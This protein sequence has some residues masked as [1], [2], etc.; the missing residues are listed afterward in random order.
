MATR[1]DPLNP[2]FYVRHP[3]L[4]RFS[5]TFGQETPEDG[6][7]RTT[8]LGTKILLINKRDASLP[9]NRALLRPVSQQ[10]QAAT[11]DFARIAEDVQT[12]LYE[13][14][15]GTLQLRDPATLSAQEK[16]IEESN[17]RVQ[18]LGSG[19]MTATLNLLTPEQLA[20]IDNMIT[21]R[22]ESG[23]KLEESNRQVIETIRRAPQLAFI[24]QSK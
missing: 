11:R 15:R 14:L 16:L 20:V 10:L 22:I 5:F 8:I 12:Y 2:S 13:Q 17:F 3:N 24:F 18:H 7:E 6:A 9:F 23:V 19:R 21:D 1:N 4:R